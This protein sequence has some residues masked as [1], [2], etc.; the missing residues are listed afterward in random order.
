MK[1]VVTQ[2]KSA[3]VLDTDRAIIHIDATLQYG[4]SPMKQSS[5]KEIK[6]ELREKLAVPLWP[7]AGRALDLRRGATYRAAAEGSIPT[8]DVGCLKRV[9]TSWLRQKLGLD[10][11]GTT[12]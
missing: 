4:F 10:E 5:M 6:R 9:S 1:S 2:V 7:T 8:L 11:P 12:A 3:K